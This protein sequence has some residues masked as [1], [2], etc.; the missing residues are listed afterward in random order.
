MFYDHDDHDYDIFV[1]AYT[2]T[3]IIGI[4]SHNKGAWEMKVSGSV[5]QQLPP[6]HLLLEA[7][8]SHLGEP[9]YVAQKLPP[10]FYS[11]WRLAP[12]VQHF[13]SNILPCTVFHSSWIRLAPF[14]V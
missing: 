2:I 13:L 1:Y 10:A 12:D 3:I 14:C 9:D 5:A 7:G 6:A 11:Q 4:A 8:K